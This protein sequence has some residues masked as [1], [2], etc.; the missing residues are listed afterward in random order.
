MKRHGFAMAA[1]FWMIL[2][3]ASI[4]T[5][6]MYN[7]WDANEQQVFE[8]VNLQRSL[9]GLSD[10]VADSRLQAAADLHSQDMAINDYFSHTSQD[11]TPFYKRISAQ[12]YQWK[13]CGENIA[14]GQ[15]NPYS[16][17][18]GTDNLQALSA[19]DMGL[20]HDGFLDWDEVGQDWTGSDWDQWDKGWMGSSGHRE[21]ILTAG[22]TDLGVGLYY[23][24]SDSGSTNYHY[25]W[26]QDFAS[27]DTAEDPVATPIPGA[28]LL[29]GSGIF[30]IVGL[31]R[32]HR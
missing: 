3:G 32:F 8:M 19:F 21:N 24:A 30:G 25:Y 29:L 23:L 28:V 22:F 31:R 5:A 20:G 16:V 17:M 13:S 18:Y 4:A 12:G 6:A 7:D 9:H 2:F 1:M 26:T 14:A 15:S 11:G 27:G 10:L